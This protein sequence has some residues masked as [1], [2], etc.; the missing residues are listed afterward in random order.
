M[1][2]ILHKRAE[3]VADFVKY[4]GNDGFYQVFTRILPPFYLPVRFSLWYHIIVARHRKTAHLP[5]AFFY[6]AIWKRMDYHAG[7]LVAAYEFHATPPALAGM[8][9][10]RALM[11]EGAE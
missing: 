7:F 8:L 3:S 5:D 2:T 11:M 6:A 10:D 1:S 9:E 4:Q